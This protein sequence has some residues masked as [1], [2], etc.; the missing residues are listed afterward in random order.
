MSEIEW[1]EIDRFIDCHRL[2]IWFAVLAALA[3]WLPIGSSVH[4]Y[5][6][7]PHLIAMLHIDKMKR[8]PDTV[9]SQNLPYAV[10]TTHIKEN[11]T[12]QIEPKPFTIFRINSLHC[13]LHSRSHGSLVPSNRRYRILIV[14][15]LPLSLSLSLSI[16]T[17]HLQTTDCP[18]LCLTCGHIPKAIFQYLIT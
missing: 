4:Y 5:A 17:S 18:I 13:M 10:R 14:A 12:T 1:N 3:G 7:L 9:N 16:Y 6:W 8:V 2:P 15:P 11:K